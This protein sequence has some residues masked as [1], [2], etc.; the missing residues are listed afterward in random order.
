MARQDSFLVDLAELLPLDHVFQIY[1]ASTTPTPCQPIYSAR[2]GTVSAGTTRESHILAVSTLV[3]EHAKQEV[4]ILALEIFVYTT[5][6]LTTVYISKAD[7]TG[8]LKLLRLPSSASSI[9]KQVSATFISHLVASRKD[10]QRIVIS[11]FAR[12]QNQYLFPGSVDNGY[13][14]VLDDRALIKWWGQTLDPI[15]RRY[16]ADSRD[17]PEVPQSEGDLATASAY[18][19]VPGCELNETRSLFPQSVRSDPPGQ[20]RWR[21]DHPLYL[22]SGHGKNTLPRNLVPRFPDDPKARFLEQL[23]AEIASSSGGSPQWRSVKSL[24]QFWEMMAYRQECSAG[25]LVGFFWLLIT[26]HTSKSKSDASNPQSSSTFTLASTGEPQAQ[27]GAVN[28]S[29]KDSLH[30]NINLT[31]ASANSTSSDD[32]NEMPDSESHSQ[33]QYRQDIDAMPALQLNNG[34]IRKDEISHSLPHRLLSQ[35]QYDDL[36]SHLLDLDFSTLA[37]ATRSTSDFASFASISMT[38]AHWGIQV[39]GKKASPTGLADQNGE[40][41]KSSLNL[42]SNNV[43]KKKKRVL[44]D[45]ATLEKTNTPQ[46]PTILS[47][48]LVRKK[49]KQANA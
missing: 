35:E 37:E 27:L 18:L 1:H 4:F 26:R 17:V 32:P 2:P 6:D 36:V 5:D 43:V 7:T 8:L 46:E 25:R 28:P 45:S 29:P 14:R 42:L 39:I 30:D 34:T 49:Q 38:S 33:G 23:D 19:V 20:S 15:L 31:G 47:A 13:K 12:A 40:T 41:S 11:L 22:L 9:T 3:N 48:G 10:R 16:T 21:A 44:E 24:E